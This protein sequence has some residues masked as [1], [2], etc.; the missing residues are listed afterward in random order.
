MWL[1]FRKEGR[2]VGEPRIRATG[3]RLI[4]M[5]T[6]EAEKET[7]EDCKTPKYCISAGFHKI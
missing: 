7:K 2:D 5:T 4:T 3:V 1:H 6:F